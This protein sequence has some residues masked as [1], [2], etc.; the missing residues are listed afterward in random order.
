[1]SSKTINLIVDHLAQ[2]GPLAAERFAAL[3][4]APLQPADDNPYWKFYTFALA[5]GPIA[6]GELRVNTAGTAALLSLAPREP[7]GLT[8]ADMDRDA[9][10]PRRSLVPNPRLPPEGADTEIWVKEGVQIS[11]QWWHTAR[12]LRRLVLE[13]PAPAEPQS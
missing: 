6:H 9:W 5:A 7:P 1:M 10:G 13:W 4:G 12:T 8:A 2:P 11:V 3:L